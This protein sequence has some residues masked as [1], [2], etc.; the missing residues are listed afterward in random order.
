MLPAVIQRQVGA[1]LRIAGTVLGLALEMVQF[2]IERYPILAS[3]RRRTQTKVRILEVADDVV[4]GESSQLAVDFRTD[5]RARRRQRTNFAHTAETQSALSLVRMIID[6]QIAPG[7][8][9]PERNS[10]VL[11]AT[12]LIQELDPEQT[13]L[14]QLGV[15]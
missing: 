3:G 6:P 1:P 13:R 4:L 2:N 8:M 14:F 5:Q 7:R 9:T 15:K 10:G 12:V 11:H